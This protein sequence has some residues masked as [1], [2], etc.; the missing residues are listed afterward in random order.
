[1]KHLFGLMR[2]LVIYN[3]RPRR[4]RDLETHYRDFV[5]AGDLAFDIGAH[6]GNRARAFSRLGAQVVAVEPQR[7]LVRYL[8]RAFAGD[9]QVTVDPRAVGDR[10]G[11]VELHLC[12]TN[13]TIASTSTEW[14]SRA[15]G[16]PGWQKY[17]FS[18][19]ETVPQVR[20]DTLIAEYG[21]P[22]FVKIDVEGREADVLAGLSRPLPA[23]SFE[24]L[25]A[26]RDVAFHSVIRLE[27]LAGE[28]DG[29]YEY[30]FSL[31]EELRL[32]MPHRWWSAAELQDYLAEIPNDGP[33]GDVYARYVPA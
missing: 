28:H 16:L 24:F 17:R 23:L 10:D 22:R 18:E 8:Q 26:D 7:R 33:S 4:I 20:L 29:T 15:P 13:P 14:V 21:V 31:G 9:P 12:P 6:T 5:T 27:H 30:N 1:M 3:M 32:V 19:V 2:S 25:P 11:V